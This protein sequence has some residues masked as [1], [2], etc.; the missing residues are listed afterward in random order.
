[1]CNYE[2]LAHIYQDRKGHKLDE[3]REHTLI[4]GV[5]FDD[6]RLYSDMSFC[7][8]IKTLPYSELITGSRE[9]EKDPDCFVPAEEENA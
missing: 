7:D 3:W 6:G 9:T 5:D 2:V 8:W 4:I 1:M